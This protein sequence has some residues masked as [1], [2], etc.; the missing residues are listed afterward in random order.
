MA[1]KR[2]VIMYFEILEQTKSLTN[3]QF[4]KLMRAVIEYNEHGVVPT[5]DEQILEI[6][7]NFIKASVDSNNERYKEKCE[8]NRQIALGRWH[9]KD[10]ANECERIR[11]DT[12]DANINKNISSFNEES[13]F[14]NINN[15]KKIQTTSSS[16]NSSSFNNSSFLK[17]NSPNGDETVSH[18]LTDT[19]KFNKNE[20]ISTLFE[21]IWAIYPRKV[22]KEQA[23]KT[24]NRKLTTLKTQDDILNKA[25]RISMLLQKHI[26]AWAE[27]TGKDG[28]KG[29]PKQYLPHFS[30]WLN[31]EIPDKEK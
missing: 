31:D 6:S 26:K 27:E 30:T 1:S 28:N 21:K 2:G 8:M 4:G 25:K 3:E 14:N 7:F 10:D 13:S 18:S 11:T 5:F 24:W 16:N 19:P 15:N 12:N 20:Y 22:G 9:K 17:E 23:K 29:R